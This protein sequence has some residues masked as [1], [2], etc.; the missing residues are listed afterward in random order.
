MKATKIP[1]DR[2]GRQGRQTHTD[3]HRLIM[4]VEKKL[5][6]L[7]TLMEWDKKIPSRLNRLRVKLDRLG[8][9]GRPYII[10]LRSSFPKN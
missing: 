8:R 1:L 10:R 6:I 9:L 3:G 4:I 7:A 5:K 2:L